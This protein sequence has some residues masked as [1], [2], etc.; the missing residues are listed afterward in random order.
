M[1]FL[2][3]GSFWL[4]LNLAFFFLFNMAIVVVLSRRLSPDTYGHYQFVLSVLGLVSLFGLPGMRRAISQSLARNRDWALVQGVVASL[5]TGI[6]G[7]IVLGVVG[8]I[9]LLRGDATLGYTF[10]AIALPFIFYNPYLAVGSYFVGK[11]QFNR[12]AINTV[13]IYGTQAIAIIGVAWFI[14]SLQA[15]LVASLLSVGVS[16][17]LTYRRVKKALHPENTDPD[18]VRFGIKMSA[19]QI[20]NVI[21]TQTDKIIL[22]YFLTPA[23][24]AIYTIAL[25]FPEN[26]TLLFD[27]VFTPLF[28]KKMTVHKPKDIFSELKKNLLVIVLGLIASVVLLWVLVY[29]LIPLFFG[30]FYSSAIP[31]ARVLLFIIPF[32]FFVNFFQSFFNA[33]KQ[34]KTF[35]HFNTTISIVLIV[36]YCICIPLWG[37][38]GAIISR[39]GFRLVSAVLGYW[40]GKKTT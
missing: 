27:K 36:L 30:D 23:E 28:F 8:L 29:W 35:F 26:F 12:I 15:I 2:S 6:L 18:V 24:L 16:G 11:E 38:W 32:S 19:I 22:F 17:Y 21:S 10:F 34:V 14:G 13:A 40:W 33:K 37:I 9:Y 39:I 3:R 31:Y 1:Q 7:A 4:M 5:K 20:L 25:V